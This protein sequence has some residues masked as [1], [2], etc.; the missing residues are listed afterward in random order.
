MQKTLSQYRITLLLYVAV[1]LL[2]FAFYYSYH[3]LQSITTDTAVIS[4]FNRI[5]TNILSYPY[6]DNKKQKQKR[7]HDIDTHITAIT[8]WFISQERKQFYVGG[9]TLQKDFEYFSHQWEE[10]KHAA[11]PSIEQLL[12]YAYSA[13]SLNFILG[14]MLLLKQQKMQNLFFINIMFSSIF[15]LL[16]IYFTRTYI[17]CQL[18]KQSIYDKETKLFNQNYFKSQLSISCAQ[19]KRT[20]QPL[21]LISIKMDLEHEAY[22][23]LAK[24]RK[25]EVLNTFGN[26]IL[27]LTRVSDMACRCDKDNVTIFTPST[28]KENALLL[29]KRIIQRLSQETILIETQM[30]LKFTTVEYD[31]NESIDALLKRMKETLN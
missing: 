31:C 13:K 4:K 22:K 8:P 16:L 14:K 5:N 18:K 28:K 3:F 20:K 23:Q 17:N 12:T 19:S 15:L 7:M 2:P 25:A 6:L 21:S 26:L 10:I 24:K 1:L 9:K 29:Q 30:Q 27:S 11:S